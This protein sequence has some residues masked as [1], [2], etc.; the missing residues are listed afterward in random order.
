[1]KRTIEVI[2]E[3]NNKPTPNADNIKLISSILLDLREQKG[4]TQIQVAKHLHLTS[5]TISHYERGVNTPS[6]EMI[7]KFA[8]YYGVSTDYLMGRCVS[9]VDYTNSLN[10]KLTKNMTCGDALEIMMNLNSQGKEI[11]ANV[12]KG[13]SS[14]SKYVK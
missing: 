11:I 7:L 3:M 14:S 1:M 12:L 13:I 6:A 4:L 10:T 2:Y 8:E 9:K 5:G